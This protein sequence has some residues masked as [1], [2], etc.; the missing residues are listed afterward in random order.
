MSSSSHYVQ[1]FFNGKIETLPICVMKILCAT[2]GARKSV[3][4]NSNFVDNSISR[5][6]ETLKIMSSVKG[7]LINFYPKH[8]KN[9]IRNRAN[10]SRTNVI[11]TL[12]ILNNKKKLP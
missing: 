11:L 2:K 7:G 4:S 6:M 5:G 9:Q 1:T 8:G 12:N 10:I 3:Y